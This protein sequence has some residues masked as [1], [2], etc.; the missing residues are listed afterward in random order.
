IAP[1]VSI[2]IAVAAQ[3]DTIEV[4]LERTDRALYA[5]KHAGK[6]CVRSAARADRS[7]GARTSGFT[8][9]DGSLS[10]SGRAAT[11]SRDES[12]AS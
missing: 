1:S 7:S 3:N 4:L 5:A 11:G 2:G 9:I 8:L 12:P 6:N 10:R